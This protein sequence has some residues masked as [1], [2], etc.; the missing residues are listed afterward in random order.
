[1]TPSPVTIGKNEKLKTVS[2][3]MKDNNIGSIPVVDENQVVIGMITD[4]DVSLALSKSDK[5]AQEMKVEDI[6]SVHLSTCNEDDEASAALDTM[7]KKK[8]GRLPV[9]DK[10]NQIKGIVTLNGIVRKLGE[11]IHR[12]E[13]LFGSKEGVM[14]TL[15]S[16]AERNHHGKK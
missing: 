13:N 1:M 6:M 5:P 2:Q 12:N 7:R 15:H 3:R 9:V 10:Y 8:V 16:L 4:R 11:G 14:D